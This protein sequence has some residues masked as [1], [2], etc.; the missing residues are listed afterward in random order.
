MPPE[1]PMS[2][3]DPYDEI[4]YAKPP[5]LPAVA[6]KTPCIPINVTLAVNQLVR[7][8]LRLQSSGPAEFIEAPFM[9]LVSGLM[10]LQK[11]VEPMLPGMAETA[12]PEQPPAGKKGRCSEVEAIAYCRS[13][14][15]PE[16][17]GQWFFAKME[18]AGWKNGGKAV[19]DWQQTIRAWNIAHYMASQKIRGPVSTA[20]QNHVSKEIDAEL[21]RVRKGFV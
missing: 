14:G 21:R 5:P 19:K 16:S 9:R 7:E 17:D 18:G 6:I 20:P 4:E 15:L 2:R 8:A 1:T 12:K 11:L 10:K 13:L 3:Q